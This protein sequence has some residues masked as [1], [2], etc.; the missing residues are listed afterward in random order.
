MIGAYFTNKPW[1]NG[2]EVADIIKP[3]NISGKEM[4]EMNRVKNIIDGWFQANSNEV[5]K[6][7][8]K[9]DTTRMGYLKNIMISLYTDVKIQARV[10]PYIKKYGDVKFFELIF[11]V[12]INTI[13]ENETTKVSSNYFNKKT[14][15]LL[16]KSIEVKILE[17]EILDS[18]M[19]S[20]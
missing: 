17:S 11:K 12:V 6:H 15:E 18:E 20:V 16:S 9:M 2:Q 14:Y 4:I 5:K 13:E 19:V 1:V 10:K 7:S 3:N 8:N